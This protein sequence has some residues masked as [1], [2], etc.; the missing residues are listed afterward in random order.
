M[1]LLNSRVRC[2]L[3]RNNYRMIILGCG[4]RSMFYSVVPIPNRLVRTDSQSIQ[5]N[6]MQCNAFPLPP[7][8]T[9]TV[10]PPGSV[11][12]RASRT[13]A[14]R[15]SSPFTMHSD[16]SQAYP[17]LSDPRSLSSDCLAGSLDHRFRS[18]ERVDTT[19]G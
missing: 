11:R 6:A 7:L 13:E 4:L 2:G 17:P 10:R 3:S 12:G 5:C 8:L 15:S 18:R 14:S 1:N 16:P 9:R 19:T